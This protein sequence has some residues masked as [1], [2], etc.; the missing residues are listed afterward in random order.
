MFLRAPPN[1]YIMFNNV[2]VKR[3]RSTRPF[4]G[5]RVRVSRTDGRTRVLY[6]GV[7]NII[8]KGA[9]TAMRHFG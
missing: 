6:S 2:V 3:G 1:C 8:V 9:V 5:L 4:N 7:H